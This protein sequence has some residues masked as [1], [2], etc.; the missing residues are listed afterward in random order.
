MLCTARVEQCGWISERRACTRR[1]SAVAAALRDD[2]VTGAPVANY[3]CCSS[4]RQRKKS[5]RHVPASEK[6]S[7]ARPHGE[8]AC[9][10]RWK[11]VAVVERADCVAR[12]PVASLNVLLEH[13]SKKKK[14]RT[15]SEMERWL[16]RGS[17]SEGVATQCERGGSTVRC[18]ACVRMSAIGALTSSMHTFLLCRKEVR[19]RQCRQ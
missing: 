5:E 14:Q 2:C 9:E 16:E 10:L 13:P 4:T 1:R 18:A 12:A 6:R 3:M 15:A 19:E 17:R 11:A 8:H 7:A